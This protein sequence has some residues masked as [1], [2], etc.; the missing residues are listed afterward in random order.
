[1]SE[2]TQPIPTRP[3]VSSLRLVLTLAAAGT[4]AGLLL[5]FVHQLTAPAIA[6]HKQRMLVEAIGD[7]LGS[8]D[9]EVWYWHDNAL[10]SELPDGVDGAKLEQIYKG[11]DE[12]GDP[13]GYA[14]VAA[15]PGFAD[16]VRLIFGYDAAGR[17]LLGM[18]VLESKETPGLGDKIEK[19]DKFVGQFEGA[20]YE[21]QG[22]KAGESSGDRHQIDMITGATIS[23]KVVIRIINNA[24][25]KWEGRIG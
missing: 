13:I 7:V 16:T 18:K 24:I 19:D 17:K 11:L 21:L 25:E 4:V 10:K 20:L 5:V 12:K 23:S 22:V 1:M 9:H 15:E 3:E 14:I 6:A 2:P 8:S